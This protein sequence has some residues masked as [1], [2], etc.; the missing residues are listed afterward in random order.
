MIAITDPNGNVTRATF[1]LARRPV[2]TTTAATP[3]APGGVV[4]TSTYDAD[5]RLLQ[6]RQSSAGTVLRTTS[7]TWTPTGQQA[8][9][10]DANGNVTTFAY[11]VL[12]RLARTTDAEGRVTTYEYDNVGRPTA[13]YNLAI[14]SAALVSQ[15][16]TPNGLRASLTD[17]NTNTN[18]TGFTYDDFDRLVTIG[19][20]AAAA[21]SPPQA[22]TTE[23]FTYDNDGNTYDNDGNIVARK[24]RADQNFTF[25]YDGLNRLIMKSVPGG[26][27]ISYSYDLAGRLT[28][29]GDNSAAIVPAVSPTGST[30][31]YAT[32]FTYDALNR[33]T[34][35]AWDPAPAVTAPAAGPLVTFGHSYDRTNR[36][37]GQTVDD[38]TWLA[39]PTGAP[40]TTSYTANALNQYSAVSGLTPS[41]GANGN[42]TGDGTYTYGY[43]AENRLVSASGAGNTASYAYD[44]RGRRKSRTV[45]GT[46]T[47]SVTDTDNREVLEYDG[48][49]GAILR[50]YAYALG[51]NDVLSQMNVP[52]GTRFSFVPDLLGS[53]VATFNMAGTLTKSIYHPYGGSP[54]PPVLFGFTGQRFDAEAGGIYYYRARHYSASLGRFLQ[55]DPIGYSNGASLYNYV[56]NDPLNLVDPTGLVAD[57]FGSGAWSSGG[58]LVPINSYVGSAGVGPTAWLQPGLLEPLVSGVPSS[59]GNSSPA[60]STPLRAAIIDSGE[61]PSVTGS[62]FQSDVNRQGHNA[63]IAASLLGVEPLMSRQ[64]NQSTTQFPARPEDDIVRVAG[65]NRSSGSPTLYCQ[66]VLCGAPTGGV[67]YPLCPTCNNRLKNGGP[68]ILLENGIKIYIPIKPED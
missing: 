30:V 66:N 39:Y 58:S 8:S 41:Y 34:G 15:T 14:Q 68:P 65:N 47:I 54:V 57:N 7:A 4:T 18:T 16:Y 46:T 42:L 67:V 24:S 12:D 19:Y 40:S 52:G 63:Q 23:T 22:A 21:P 45:N 5:G 29:V 6:A 1:D 37:I 10:T 61:A 20:P 38:N 31:T 26:Q 53:V 13:T 27:T 17:A 9:A 35:I 60:G 36:R 59:L 62:P 50:W 48:S 49:S 44:G 11:D 56:N 3:A 28:S 25:D 64:P 51:P 2:E 55:A 32:T 43:D 33:P